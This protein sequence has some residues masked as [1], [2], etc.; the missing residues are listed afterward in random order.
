[1]RILLSLFLLL[2]FVG[3]SRSQVI[4]GVEIVR[5]RII[6]GDWD[7]VTKR[8]PVA[9][10]FTIA[11]EWHMYWLNP[12][13]AGSPPKVEWKLP[14]G[15]LAKGLQFP[16][17]KRV[18]EDDMVSY[19]YYD[20]LIL[21]EEI[22][23]PTKPTNESLAATIKWMVCKDICVSGEMEVSG[24][25]DEFKSAFDWP[26][27]PLVPSFADEGLV[28]QPLPD[29]SLSSFAGATTYYDVIRN[30]ARVVVKD[31]FPLL[32]TDVPIDVFAIDGS[33]A[34]RY[35]RGFE[36]SHLNGIL[37]LDDKVYWLKQP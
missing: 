7:P 12:G 14:D 33:V 37:F 20:K 17:P 16:V 11:P 13:D 6:A 2:L 31:V 18:E 34:V 19:A 25:L 35:N 1:M 24:S 8:F 26:K 23:S 4:D 9:I 32:T 28:L 5:P 3:T 15:W 29:A 30:G 27:L 10:E 36:F 21:I 22:Y